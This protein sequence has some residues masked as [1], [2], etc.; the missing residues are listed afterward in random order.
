M[1]K[2]LLACVASLFICLANA[3]V[4]DADRNAAMDLVKKHQK[5]L[6]LVSNDL[7][8]M[9][10][11][12]S[13]VDK[14]TGIRYVYLLQTYKGIIVSKQMQV[15]SF[16]NDQLLSQAGRRLDRMDQRVDNISAI[17]SLPAQ[18]AVMSAIADRKLTAKSAASVLKSTADGQ[19]IEFNDMG[20]SREHITAQLLWIPDELGKTVSL[21]W[22]VYIIQ[23]TSS[24]YWLVSVHA[25]SGKT[26]RVENLTNYDSWPTHDHENNATAERNAGQAHST[27]NTT[28]GNNTISNNESPQSPSIINGASYRVIP[29]PAENPEAPGGAPAL[30]N[31][32]WSA[33][34]GNATTLGWHTGLGGTDYAYTRGNNVWAYHDRSNNNAGDPSRSAQSLTGTDPLNF[35]YVPNLAV[36]PTQTTPVTN[37]QFAITNLFY[38]NN[39]IH[40]VMYQYGFTEASA[41]FQDDN[42]GRGGVGNDHVN[43]E[44]Q[45]GSG[46]NNANFSTPADGG[47]GRMQMYLFNRNGASP[48]RDGDLDNGVVVH[49]YGHGIS[50]RLTGGGTSGCLG[51]AEQMGEGW[52]DF[53][54]IMFTQNWAT[55]NLNSGF[56]GRRTVGAYALNNVSN[57]PASP[58]NSGFRHYAYTTDMT[59]NPLTYA[60]ING[61]LLGTAVH[62]IGEVWC[63]TLWD[64][65]WNIIQQENSIN[66]NIYNVAGG[67]GNV[68]A[69]RLVTEGLKL[70]TCNPG[71]IDGRDAIIQAD[72]NLYGGVHVCT[73][74]EAFRR[75]GLGASAS[76]GSSSS[77][78][79]QV[80]AFDV[81]KPV[82]TLTQP[83]VAGI[84]ESQDINYSNTVTVECT[85]I[86]NYLL[87]D[88]LPANVSF[89]SATNGGTY[90]AGTR[91]ISWVV[92]QAAGT[93][94]NYDFVVNINAGAYVP[95]VAIFNEGV[96]VA[97]IPNNFTA[98]SSTSAVW[99]V[100]S[101]QYYSSPVSFFTPGTINTSNQT[102]SHTNS[103]SLPALP[104]ELSFIHSYDN[105]LKWEGSVIEISTNGGTTWADIG[106]S[107]FLQEGYNGSILSNSTASIA[108]RR[109]FTGN[110]GGFVR[111]I[112]NLSPYANQPNVKFRW[113]FASDNAV[114]SVGWY[115]DDIS[116]TAI[117]KVLMK[118][119]LF[120]EAV[121]VIRTSNTI[122]PI[123]A[124]NC[125]LATMQ[126]P[127]VTQSTCFALASIVVNATGGGTL[128][129][130]LNAVYQAGN[131]FT[132]LTPGTYQVSVRSLDNP[133]CL[134]T[135]PD[136]IILNPVTGP[137]I[138]SVTT[139]QTTCADPTG[140]IMI[141]A[142]SNETLE[143]SINGIDFQ[144]SPVFSNLNPGSFMVVVKVQGSSSCITGYGSNPVIITLPSSYQAIYAGPPVAIPDNNPTGVNIILPVSG[145]STIEDL[146]FRFKPAAGATC[147]TTAGNVNAA[148]D[149]TFIGDLSFTLTSP[150]GTSVA[151]MIKRGTGGNNIC[152]LVLDDDGGYP[153]ITTL[154]NTG[155]V[156]GNY[157]PESPFSVFDGQDPNGNWILFVKDDAAEDSGKVRGFSLDFT[158]APCCYPPTISNVQITPQ[159]CPTSN[160][161]SLVVE[162][163][164]VGPLEY[165][166]DNG[167][168]WQI[169]NTFSGLPTGFYNVK[170]R[171]FNLPNCV[172]TYALNG[173]VE[174]TNAAAISVTAIASIPATCSLATGSIQVS[175]TSPNGPV[176]YSIDG[177][178]W[179]AQ[180]TTISGLAPGTYNIQGRMAGL[181]DCS[182]ALG[183]TSVGA[184]PVLPDFSFIGG[185]NATCIVPTG[186]VGAD[187]SS[188]SGAVEL[189]IDGTTWFSS[190]HTFTN[191]VPGSY[192][193]VARLVNFPDCGA[194]RSWTV[195]APAPSPAT[196]GAVQGL[197]NVCSYIGTST[198]LTYSV[199]A[200]PGATS[201]NW[202]VPPTVTLVSGQGTNSITVTINS[203]FLSNVNKLFRVTASNT[204]G[205][206]GERLYWLLAQLPNT[207]GVISGPV[208]ACSLLGSSAS[209]SVT[210]VAGA[211]SYVWTAQPGTTI[212]PAGPGVLGNAVTISFPAGFTSSA[213]TVTAVN[214]CGG[215]G[216]RSLTIVRNN[217]ATPGLI[218]GPTNVCAN[219]GST[220]TAASYSV[221]VQANATGYTWTV[222]AAVTDL[223]GQGTNSISFTYPD[224]FTSGSI[225][226]TATNGCGTSAARS[227][228][229]SRLNPATPSPIDVIQTQVCGAPGG[230]AFSYTL[231]AM[232]ANAT[233]ILWTIPAAGTLVSGQGTSS[234]TISYP[235]AAVSGTVTAQAIANCASSTIR[236]TPVKLPACPVLPFA[237]KNPVDKNHAVQN[238]TGLAG[239]LDV[240]VSPNPA[241]NDFRLDIL[242]AQKESIIITVTDNLGRMLKTFTARSGQPTS[243]GADWK[244]GAYLLKVQQGASFIT[245]KL[246]KL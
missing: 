89:V 202:T 96:S 180:G 51:N 194:S 43:A 123:I 115:V 174:I 112:I 185:T 245:K 243:F 14:S 160:G 107:N 79:D 39:I 133:N 106:E 82:V 21:A 58:P 45:D 47:S 84:P 224:G 214:E 72:R 156:S 237:G 93:S 192:E 98:A 22:Q 86:S 157:S 12:N 97:S 23:N 3:Q 210:P 104:A 220:G 63:A 152:S 233:S 69:M 134:V 13:Y 140:G 41:N 143:Y 131:T 236:S 8:N 162:A 90:N 239:S 100:S 36:D 170:A 201:Y 169:S 31:N 52:S 195:E 75:R 121:Q 59:V 25:A 177:T 92:N 17:P 229:V 109:A 119:T 181:P 77:A 187:A 7:E 190:P 221:P 148:V 10:V 173:S 138:T 83:N 216:A 66:P 242:S 238:S 226:V 191:L 6:N 244:A 231:A 11:S 85:A 91:V 19:K 151:F 103:L 200:V 199:A 128:E 34:P 38:W 4:T 166:V 144:P 27:I 118:S 30:V 101:A 150:A 78:T 62:N 147:N 94:V 99:S 206:S 178:T 161:G 158:L 234:I 149:H 26:L 1:R 141:Q 135:W 32:P 24:D 203:N 67:G 113:R 186:S 146:N 212:I 111:S 81:D 137:S 213:V 129:Y 29:F 179:V 196:P 110:S 171:L 49:E 18:S 54:A 60:D 95:P 88:T 235:D 5:T 46:S 139:T 68:I 208:N 223:S 76:Q 207:P 155:A 108:G 218:T 230:R 20:V 168:T 64:M 175:A 117:A 61:P 197:T 142:T 130:G 222:P 57:F 132:G 124:S 204:C 15:L 198:Q 50:N 33:A 65:T 102:L 114:A 165:S 184:A 37:Q 44:A 189:S 28:I 232:P 193:V 240:K 215:S 80:A 127:T 9:I 126:A 246:I 217:P 209:Y 48:L 122:M 71:F 188:T 125:V 116:I 145:L 70:Q 87:T 176:E 53:Y 183:T 167:S 2:L 159:V 241:V 153:S 56:T 227:L 55:S 163:T 16:R 164:G 35:D 40:D 211:A 172:G 219:I 154:P 74:K 105:E 228:A 182:A 225:S 73:I 120:N 136:L 42:Q 205:T